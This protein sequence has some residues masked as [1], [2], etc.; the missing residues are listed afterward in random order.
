MLPSV[1][2][3]WLN[4][5]KK[6][7]P[8]LLAK[9][10]YI[11]EEVTSIVHELQCMDLRKDPQNYL[12]LLTQLHTTQERLLALLEKILEQCVHKQRRCR[13]Y[14]LKFP[15]DIVNGNMTSHLLF[16]AELMVGGT[17]IEVE[18]ADGVILRPLA[19]ELLRSLENVRHVLREQSLEDPGIYPDHVHQALLHYDNL[20]AEFELRYTS[21]VVTVK[22]PEEIY[23]Q[24]EVVVLFCETVSRAMKLGYL[25][26]EMIDN[27]EP[28]LMISI[29]RL[30][31]ISG[32]L[33]YPDGPLSLQKSPGEMCE[34]F[35]PFY[36]LLKKIRELLCI[37]TEDELFS[38]ERALCSHSSEDPTLHLPYLSESPDSGNQSNS[39]RHP[40]HEPSTVEISENSSSR[41]QRFS[42]YTDSNL[43]LKNTAKCYCAAD[44]HSTSSTT[45]EINL[46][47]NPC[48]SSTNKQV[49]SMSDVPKNGET[50]EM[51]SQYVQTKC[52]V[53]CRNR[54][55]NF[56]DVRA[57][58]QSDSDMLHRLFVC[59]AGVADQLQTNFASDLR[60]I[61][62]TVFEV[63]SSTPQEE[64]QKNKEDAFRL[65][66]CSVCQNLE[67]QENVSP[68]WVPDSRSNQ[69]MSCCAPFTLLRRRH[70]C[71]SCGK[72]FCSRCSG[73]TASLPPFG[74]MPPVRVCSHCYHVHCNR[75]EKG[76][77][78]I[79]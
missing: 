25:N 61:L 24:Q 6:S 39:R 52:N 44:G 13:D 56:R 79:E 46:N 59:I 38:L 58:Y 3:R 70:H 43:S 54:K 33:I 28:Q 20:C 8:R 50:L 78:K 4:K 26:Q 53:K 21:L 64:K 27:C 67:Q 63:V 40:N 23:E 73:Y 65:P 57:R 29:P 75:G 37:L 34:L 7:D 60:I 45:L 14:Q 55:V 74:N 69:C 35:S 9:F 30:A 32:L 42:E 62:K 71:R 72:I 16:A 5:P 77:G 51:K 11:D 18:E 1:V 12:I 47:S 22:T 19:Q 76:A 15:D 41:I 68:E 2:R 10:F 36:G 48:S 66:D 17:Y 31:I 49:D